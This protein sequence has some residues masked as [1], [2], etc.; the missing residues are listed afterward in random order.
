[1]TKQIALGGGAALGFLILGAV[2]PASWPAAAQQIVVSFA[3]IAGGIPLAMAGLDAW[4]I[5]R[6]KKKD[7]AN[8]GLFETRAAEAEAKADKA[9]RES[10]SRQD[11]M[12]RKLD[13]IQ[14][15]LKTQTIQNRN[16]NQL[17]LEATNQ[18]IQSGIQLRNAESQIVELTAEIVRLR[19][20][21]KAVAEISAKVDKVDK[22]VKQ[23]ARA[24]SD[25]T[26]MPTVDMDSDLDEE[27][28]PP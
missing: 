1:M 26:T 14:S 11:E 8:R 24:M 5:S 28:T 4:L 6:R 13:S 19:L 12:N 9:D 3:I 18:H 21:V 23:V 25:S 16:L 10:K 17:L 27:V 20:G 2:N 7:E 15:D 22:H